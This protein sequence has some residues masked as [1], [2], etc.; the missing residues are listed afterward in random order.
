MIVLDDFAVQPR[1]F[2]DRP[3]RALFTLGKAGQHFFGKANQV[4]QTSCDCRTR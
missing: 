1:N 2:V 4:A 3:G